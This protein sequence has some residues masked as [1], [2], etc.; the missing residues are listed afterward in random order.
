MI[1]NKE[2]SNFPRIIKCFSKTKQK[3]VEKVYFNKSF[4]I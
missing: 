3:I 4:Y 1:E 2:F